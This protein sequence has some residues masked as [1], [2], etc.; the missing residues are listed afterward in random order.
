MLNAHPPTTLPFV[1]LAK[2]R[3]FCLQPTSI[4]LLHLH[5]NVNHC[6]SPN[7]PS[8]T[9]LLMLFLLANSLDTSPIPPPLVPQLHPYHHTHPTPS[10][11]T[12]SIA[13]VTR[14]VQL[15]PPIPPQAPHPSRHRLHHLTPASLHLRRTFSYPPTAT[16]FPATPTIALSFPLT[17]MRSTAGGPPPRHATHNNPTTTSSQ[18]RC[19]T[20]TVCNLAFGYGRAV[21]SHASPATGIAQAPEVPLAPTSGSFRG[22][23]PSYSARQLQC[24]TPNAFRAPPQLGLDVPG[25]TPAAL[26]HLSCCPA[27]TLSLRRS[28]HSFGMTPETADPREAYSR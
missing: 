10:P 18:T 20:P 25:A 5:T 23:G 22:V 27:T 13:T 26:K 15:P 19:L 2:H 9:S 3:E 1:P 8:S 6:I 21:I 24:A 28:G 16:P 4:L 14:H 7:L 17:P 11:A 12:Y